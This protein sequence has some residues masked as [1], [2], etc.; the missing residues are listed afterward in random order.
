MRTDSSLHLSV[1]IVVAGVSGA[2]KTTVGRILADTF[3]VKFFDADDLHPAENIAKMRS[4]Q[5]LTD[6]DRQGWLD[7]VGHRLMT[8]TPV[9]ACSALKQKYRNRLREA[10]PDV[11]VIFLQV[12][13][14]AGRQRLDNRQ[15]HFMPASLLES[16]L[17]AVELPSTT[18]KGV[19]LSADGEVSI[20]VQNAIGVILAT[21]AGRRS[22]G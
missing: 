18:E 17:A 11:L 2:G 10:R 19:T 4:G 6:A 21:C 5:P 13:R 14:G 12:R 9:V 1:P 22:I 20:V 7:S 15:G 8:G 3:G 16:Q